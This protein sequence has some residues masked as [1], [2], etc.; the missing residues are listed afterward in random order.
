MTKDRTVGLVCPTQRIRWD[1]SL[2][3]TSDRRSQGKERALS[4]S[5][6]LALSL[7][8]RFSFSSLS[9]CI[10]PLILLLHLPS[11]ADRSPLLPSSLSL[12]IEGKR[13][14]EEEGS[15]WTKP[16]NKK[17]IGSRYKGKF[18][19]RSLN[20]NSDFSA[21]FISLVFFENNDFWN[22]QPPL[23][24]YYWQNF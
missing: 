20:G 23:L 24:S 5:L 8:A 12:H 16:R 13:K 22:C 10:P 3:T 14:G 15:W 17:V 18:L 19:R 6:P 7:T 2:N 11:Q 1:W 9:C 21:V 4:P